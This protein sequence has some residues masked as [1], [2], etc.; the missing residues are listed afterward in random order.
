MILISASPTPGNAATKQAKPKK[1]EVPEFPQDY[2]GRV[3]K[4][5]YLRALFSLDEEKATEY[6]NGV[7]VASPFNDP[8]EL[9]HQGWIQ[10]VFRYPYK[11]ED[12]GVS[13]VPP[14]YGNALDEAFKDE[15]LPVDKTQ[16]AVYYYKHNSRYMKDNIWS[17]VSNLEGFPHLL[18]FDSLRVLL[19]HPSSIRKCNGPDLWCYRF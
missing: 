2:E 6:N 10:L 4:G 1:V 5:Q 8:D 7:S 11:D 19:A 17:Q 12:E 15:G 13:P 18:Y 16:A 9:W 14:S 3:K